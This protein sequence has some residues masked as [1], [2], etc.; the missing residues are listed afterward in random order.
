MPKPLSITSRTLLNLTLAVP[1]GV[2]LYALDDPPQTARAYCTICSSGYC[3]PDYSNLGGY[4]VCPL[5]SKI[6]DPP[7][8]P[9]LKR[10]PL[11]PVVG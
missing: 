3:R 11:S 8:V 10:S 4:Y 1:L 7:A 9:V 5:L 2:A 6:A